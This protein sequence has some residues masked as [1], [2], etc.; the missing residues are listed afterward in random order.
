MEI[1]EERQDR[2][3]VKEWDHMKSKGGKERE[4]CASETLCTANLE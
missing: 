3:N 4:P 1:K 2:L